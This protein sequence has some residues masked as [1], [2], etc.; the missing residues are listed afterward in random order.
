MVSF[1][2]ISAKSSHL[3]GGL[4]GVATETVDNAIAERKTDSFIVKDEYSNREKISAW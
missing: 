4:S 2:G 3:C 1:I